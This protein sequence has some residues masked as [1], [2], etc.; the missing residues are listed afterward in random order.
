MTNRDILVNLVGEWAQVYRSEDEVFV[1]VN[2][3]LYSDLADDVEALEYGI[4]CEPDVL[5]PKANLKD[6][7]DHI[8]SVKD[9]SIRFVTSINTRAKVSLI[10]IFC[11]YTPKLLS[12]MV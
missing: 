7:Y 8:T 11:R 4:N 2:P 6:Y 3:V 9:N 5:I 10:S 1:T 12:Y